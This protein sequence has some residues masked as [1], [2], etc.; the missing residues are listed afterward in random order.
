LVKR[1]P[2][3]V[4]E[5]QPRI[6]HRD[7]VAPHTRYPS[8]LAV[9]PAR[10]EVCFDEEPT[11][12]RVRVVGRPQVL[13]N[14]TV[15]GDSFWRENGTHLLQQLKCALTCW[16]LGETGHELLLR[17]GLVS[18]TKRSILRVIVVVSRLAQ[19]RLVEHRPLLLVVVVTSLI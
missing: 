2:R 11:G 19:I 14:V 7:G 15:L 3:A 6:R 5:I 4:P 17:R 18:E 9:I 8:L 13:R 10:R 16:M 12:Q 1:A